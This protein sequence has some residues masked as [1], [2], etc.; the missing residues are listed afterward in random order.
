MHGERHPARDDQRRQQ[1]GD[2]PEHRAGDQRRLHERQREQLADA[3]ERD[4]PAHVV[5]PVAVRGVRAVRPDHD[6][7]VAHAQHVD[8][9]AVELR[10]HRRGHHL[11]RPPDPEAAVHQVQHPVH[12]RQDRVDLVGDEHDGGA[13]RPPPLVDQRGDAGLVGQVEREQ[14]LVAQQHG[15]VAD[16]RLG[17]PQPL[18]LAAGEAPDRRVRVARAADRGQR[19]VHPGPAH[20]APAEADAR[21]VPVQAE[22]DEV[23]PAQRQVR[24]QRL[25]LRDVADVRAAPPRF[26]AGD[27]HLAR[28]QRLEPEQHAHQR[29]LARPVGAEDRDELAG[30]DVEVE[31]APERPLP[32]RQP[33]AAEADRGRDGGAGRPGAARRRREGHRAPPLMATI[34]DSL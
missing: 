14:R 31:A 1:P 22:P 20:P 13:G 26:P 33:G 2:E 21:P 9:C 17:H 34:V 29:G 3:L 7:P 6:Q 11:V 24:V 23:A 8:L 10:Q 16:Q 5:V 15:R 12:Q 32:E 4:Q 19:R 28:G 25:L 18:L 27:P 30:L